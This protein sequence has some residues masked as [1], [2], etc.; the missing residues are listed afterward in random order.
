MINVPHIVYA[1]IDPESY[2]VRY[3][4]K[5]SSM[6][7]RPREPHSAHCASWIK[8][9]EKRN[10]KP[11]IRVL[12]FYDDHEECR[13]DEIYWIAKFR[14]IGFD[15]TNIMDDGEGTTPGYKQ[16]RD[17]VEK[18]AAKLRGK[19]RSIEI[20]EKI[21]RSLTGRNGFVVGICLNCTKEFVTIPSQSRRKFCNK[22]CCDEFKKG[23]TLSYRIRKEG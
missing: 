18:R 3:V 17:V 16:P 8:S 5:S 13:A 15:L 21:S 22:S 20:C 12:G 4:G 11:A 10:L 6:F 1:L 19:K 2:D 23:K 7:K 14:Q 9:L